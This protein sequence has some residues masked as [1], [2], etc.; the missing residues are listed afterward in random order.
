M[1]ME[2][3]TLGRS[4][5]E[6]TA[7][8]LGCMRISG[9]SQFIDGTKGEWSGIPDT[10][11]KIRCLH[12]AMDKGVTLFDTSMAYGC[13]ENEETLGKAFSDRRDKVIIATK[14]GNLM[15][16]ASRT[17]MRRKGGPFLAKAGTFPDWI[18]WS[19]EQSLRRLRTDY[20]DLYQCH[21][22]MADNG[23]EMMETLERLV[24]EGKIRWYGW[25]TDDA[26]RVRTFAQG[27]HCAAAELALNVLRST[28]EA[29]EV[30][31]ESN[32]AALIRSPLGGGLLA[33][34]EQ[35]IKQTEANIEKMKE[36]DAIRE[37]LT[38]EGRSVVQG[39]I[40][41]LWAR[42]DVT[43]P[44]PGFRTME[45]LE[46]L[47]GAL[48]FGPLTQEQMAEIETIQNEIP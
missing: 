37:I 27:E 13:G 12:T 32:L 9:P 3:R 48:Q 45:Q 36:L 30:C 28:N 39:A 11:G 29:L 21:A 43:V 4:G 6:V 5:I 41:W 2:K 15:D 23:E 10:K 33:K 35:D 18:R 47:C 8:G 38:S 22:G 42:S 16:E 44:I 34:S 14:F 17:L 26:D 25:S 19:C 24:Q 7:L 46:G 40:C 31:E 20:I 1:G